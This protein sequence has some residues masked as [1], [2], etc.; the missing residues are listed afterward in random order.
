MRKHGSINPEELTILNDQDA[1]APEVIHRAVN[2]IERAITSN[3]YGSHNYQSM[4]LKCVHLT[5]D[6][7]NTLMELFAQYLLE[8]ITYIQ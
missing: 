6:Q 1:E 8:R 2:R 5:S 7:Q 4:I 3:E